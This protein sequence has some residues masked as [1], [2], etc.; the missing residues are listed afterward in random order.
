MQHDWISEPVHDQDGLDGGAVAVVQ[1][2]AD[3][4]RWRMTGV[5]VNGNYGTASSDFDGVDQLRKDIHDRRVSLLGLERRPGVVHVESES[6]GVSDQ[7]KS[8]SAII[9]IRVA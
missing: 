2:E 7:R 5:A 1:P 3:K 9:G 8:R 6:Y 4:S